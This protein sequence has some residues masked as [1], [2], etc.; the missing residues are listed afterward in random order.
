MDISTERCRAI[1]YARVS[2][3]E[4]AASGLGLAAQRSAIS[5][6]VD[7]HGWQICQEIIDDGVSGTT[8]VD[9]RPALSEAR[10]A[11]DR[12]D[13][14]VLIVAKLDRLSRSMSDFAR[15]AQ[16]AIDRKWAIVALDIGVDDLT[17]G[18]AC[19]Q[20]DGCC[21]STR[22]PSRVSKDQR[23]SGS[24]QGFR[25]SSRPTGRTGGRDPRIHS[26]AP[27]S[28]EHFAGGSV[29][30]LT[31]RAFPRPEEGAGGHL[32]SWRWSGRLS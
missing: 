8:G 28:G 24:S 9:K 22:S 2:T 16:R 17:V 30:I 29:R 6:H 25:G 12:S 3:T 1:T 20:Y 15:L 19:R 13:A 10:C 18:G 27:R 4:Q 31:Q 23:C 32:P 26:G 21:C 14:D 5:H 11:L 7:A